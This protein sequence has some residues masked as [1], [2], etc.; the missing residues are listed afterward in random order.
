LILDE[1]LSVGDARFLRRCER[2]MEEFSEQGTTLLLVSHDVKAV[3]E[4]CERAIWLEKGRIEASG[5][6]DEVVDRYLAFS[7]SG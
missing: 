4:N 7:A 2:R 6:A 1:V 3:R 5:P